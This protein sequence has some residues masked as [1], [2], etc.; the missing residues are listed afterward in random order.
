MVANI[1]PDKDD[2][3]KYTYIRRIASAHYT[4]KIAQQQRFKIVAHAPHYWSRGSVYRTF[5]TCALALL[6]TRH[7]RLLSNVTPMPAETLYKHRPSLSYEHHNDFPHHN[8][9]LPP[10][11]LL[12]THAPPPPTLVPRKLKYSSICTSSFYLRSMVSAASA[13]Q[14]SLYL[15]QPGRATI[16]LKLRY[17]CFIQRLLQ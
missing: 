6:S 12:S 13:P 8:H 7:C 1:Y 14:R 9:H 4:G 16:A 5:C 3:K 10:R 11:C 15:S 17:S 2:Y